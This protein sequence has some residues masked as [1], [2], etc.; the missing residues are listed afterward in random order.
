[1]LQSH[2]KNCH[3][4]LRYRECSPWNSTRK[5]QSNWKT[6]T[7]FRARGFLR[8]TALLV[9]FRVG[10]SD[11][12]SLCTSKLHYLFNKSERVLFVCSF[13]GQNKPDSSYSLKKS[14]KVK[15]RDF[16]I[17]QKKIKTSL[18]YCLGITTKSYLHVI[19]FEMDCTIIYTNLHE[20]F[21]Q[22]ISWRNCRVNS[23]KFIDNCWK[24]CQ[25]MAD[26]KKV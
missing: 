6:W 22:F 26:M 20:L 9:P 3:G 23:G 2:N 18:A 19:L 1:M 17:K 16:I 12:R 7:K 24:S 15:I 21:C 11:Q 25:V 4:H 5:R 8:K 10:V 13:L 14:L